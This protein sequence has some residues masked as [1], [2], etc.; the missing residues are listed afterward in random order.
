MV[1]FSAIVFK[2]NALMNIAFFK[3]TWK[4]NLTSGR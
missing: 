3:L 1:E 2:L 4:Y